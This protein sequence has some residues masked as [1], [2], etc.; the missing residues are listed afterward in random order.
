VQVKIV[1]ANSANRAVNQ[2]TGHP[3]VAG[4]PV[5]NWKIMSKQ[6]F[7][8]HVIAYSHWYVRLGRRCENFL[9]GVTDTFPLW[10]YS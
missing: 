9:L 5:R 4:T 2:W 7:T 10:S 8:I 1:L 6:S 3:L